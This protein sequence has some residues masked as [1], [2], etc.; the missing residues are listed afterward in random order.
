MKRKVVNSKSS[1]TTGSA[2]A[3]KTS[4]ANTPASGTSG[5]QSLR[6]LDENG[7]STQL[8]NGSSKQKSNKK[9]GM[10]ADQSMDQPCTT[11]T[12]VNSQKSMGQHGTK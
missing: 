4:G 7:K 12:S 8:L 2:K 1:S 10:P 5:G 9:M 3:P 6:L 11:S